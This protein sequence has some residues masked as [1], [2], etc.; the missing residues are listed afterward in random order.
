MPGS[1]DQ[2]SQVPITGS[3]TANGQ[4][5]D[6]TSP[7]PGTTIIQLT[8]T[9]SG[10]IVLE[11]SNDNTNFKILDV[12]SFTSKLFTAS[13]TATD[14][15]AGNTNG[16]QFYRVRSTA[17]TS[18]TAVLSVYGA[19]AASIVFA[20]S[21]LRG[22]SDGTLIG[23]TGDRLKTDVTGSVTANAGTNLNTSA[24][25]LE[26][27]QSAQNTLIGA[28]TETAPA[29]DTASS[30]LNGRLQRIAQRITSLIALLPASLGQKASASSLAVTLSTE[31]EA[32]IGAVTETAP[33]S[34]TASSGLN[35]R[36]QRIAQ[37]LSSLIALIPT[38]VGTAFFTR[39]SDGTDVAAVSTSG[40]LKVNE[41]LK[42]GGVQGLLSIP[43]A[44]TPVEAKVGVSRLS[45]RVFLQI[46]PN[47]N[48]LFYGFDNTVTVTN[49]TPIGNG[50]PVAFSIDPDSTF[51]IWLVSA[52]NSKS[53]QIL[54]SP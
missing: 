52:N 25:A 46:T 28:V 22:A 43:T 7:N 19:D 36:L 35:G 15:Y 16:F 21:Q 10:T 44:N 32:E 29:S 5:F 49:G 13:M 8:G 11:G 48:G 6:L 33:A 38:V 12:M 20:L 17:W 18:G 42:N 41:G 27:T 51:Q 24:L 50:Q 2:Q 23:N 1:I 26:T 31:Q 54:E 3:F 47:Q 39:I 30:G 4:S 45:G 14:T 9:W 40:A 37:R 53:A 34:D